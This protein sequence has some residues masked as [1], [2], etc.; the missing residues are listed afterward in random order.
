MVINN[1]RNR[2]KLLRLHELCMGLLKYLGSLG[3]VLFGILMLIFGFIALIVSPVAIA[4]K[5][6]VEVS[7][8][9]AFF[10]IIVGVVV[11]VIGGYYKRRN[12]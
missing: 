2:F 8:G 11:I 12:Q 3:L 10:F 7:L 5:M 1:Y 9:I 4:Q 6:P